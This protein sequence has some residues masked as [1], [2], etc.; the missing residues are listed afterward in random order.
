MQ[1]T[2]T[3]VFMVAGDYQI[4]WGYQRDVQ[5]AQTLFLKACKLNQY[6]ACNY[7]ANMFA[8]GLSTPKDKKRAAAL[9]EKSCKGGSAAGC[10][11]WGITICP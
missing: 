10:K 2:V 9:Y 8:T 1:M 7:A 6:E 5:K 11:K 4:G 3:L